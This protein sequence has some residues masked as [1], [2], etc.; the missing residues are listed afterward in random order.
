MLVVA[1][2]EV[3]VEVALLLLLL[4]LQ[5]QEAAIPKRDRLIQVCHS[6][7]MFERVHALATIL[8]INE[9]AVM[10]GLTVSERRRMWQNR[11]KILE[12]P[13]W[14]LA[15]I[16]KA[17]TGANTTW[18]DTMTARP[19]DGPDG[20]LTIALGHGNEYRCP[21]QRLFRPH[22]CTLQGPLGPA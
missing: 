8:I 3:E 14:V 6:D 10:G 22:W 11:I 21:H 18:A 7:H 9:K 5:E 1:E 16:L 2:V 20:L 19:I 17:S 4:P 12:K 15:P 13:P